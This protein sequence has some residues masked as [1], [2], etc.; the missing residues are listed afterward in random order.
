MLFRLFCRIFAGIFSAENVLTQF[1]RTILKKKAN[2][3]YPTTAVYATLLPISVPMAFIMSC[4]Y[5]P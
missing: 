1:S 2:S 4:N 5:N 3:K